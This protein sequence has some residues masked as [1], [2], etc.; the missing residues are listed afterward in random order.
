VKLSIDDTPLLGASLG[1]PEE[2]PAIDENRELII[3]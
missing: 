1:G 3:A 2:V